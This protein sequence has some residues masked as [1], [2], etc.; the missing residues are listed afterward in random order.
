V[1]PRKKKETLARPGDPIVSKNGVV[2]D[3]ELPRSAK[4]MDNL[5]APIGSNQS[6]TSINPVTFRSSKRKNLNE[7][8]A[9]PNVIN[10]VAAL[11]MYTVLGV[12]E[13]EIADTLGI[14]TMQLNEL[15]EHSAF[16]ECFNA[17]INELISAN[18]DAIQARIASYA[19]RA[20]DNIF[21]IAEA[22]E[23]DET[24]LRA[25]QDLADRA[26]IGA[27]QLADRKGALSGASLRIVI[28]DEDKTVDVKLNLGD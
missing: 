20:V 26:G 25:S 15:R 6:N 17:V 16:D 22:A 14:T 21:N 1:A 7:L 9:P 5:P 12:G 23:K 27:K 13:R 3:P 24:R 8:P 11:F 18:S 28:L 19:T 10:G 4:V 2:V